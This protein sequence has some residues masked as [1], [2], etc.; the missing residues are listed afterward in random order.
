MK[1]RALGSIDFGE[2]HEGQ[3]KGPHTKDLI[4][5]QELSGV[6]CLSKFYILPETSSLQKYCL[7]FR[8][9]E[10]SGHWA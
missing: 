9:L 3:Q 2:V 5:A 7:N 4:Y 1:N 6:S 10:S 8:Q